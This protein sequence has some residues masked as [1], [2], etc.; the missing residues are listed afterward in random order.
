VLLR[1][2]IDPANGEIE[3]SFAEAIDQASNAVG[4]RTRAAR[5]KDVDL[6]R[7]ARPALYLV[8]WRSAQQT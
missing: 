4:L 6:A 2:E 8:H 7:P 1:A 3:L 5:S